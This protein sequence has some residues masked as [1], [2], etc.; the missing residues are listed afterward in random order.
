MP[1]CMYCGQNH[2][3]EQVY[4]CR[5]LWFLQFSDLLTQMTPDELEEFARDVRAELEG[6][7]EPSE[8]T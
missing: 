4:A 1:K 3:A 5:E 2:E 6:D 7:N 8:E